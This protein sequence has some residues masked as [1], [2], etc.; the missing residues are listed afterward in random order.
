M[1]LL[2]AESDPE[3]QVRVKAFGQ[4]L[5]ALDWREGDNVNIEYRFAAGDFDR[6]RAFAKELVEL[7]PDVIITNSIQPIIPVW[8]QTRIPFIFAMAVD[9]VVVGLIKSL[10]HPDQ[11]MTG[12]TTFEYAI[13]GKWLELL[14]AIAP[15]VKRV[16]I[17]LNPD[18]WD[19]TLSPPRGDWKEWLHQAEAF[20]PSFAVEAIPVP[21]Q[22]PN[23]F[24][25]VINLKTERPLQLKVQRQVLVRT[26]EVRERKGG[27]SLGCWAARPLRGRSSRARNSPR[28][29][30]LVFCVL[31]LRNEM[32]IL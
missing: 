22:Q 18:A 7:K 24:E 3:A 2:F 8:Q 28:S 25:L 31:G 15:R 27:I 16:G 23:K 11:T 5:R 21:V 20:A 4:G 26:D 10:S 30:R 32:W 14:K 12:F 19:R 17:I 29:Q 9:P 6:M 13:V 1:L